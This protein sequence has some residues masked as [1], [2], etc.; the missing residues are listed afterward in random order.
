MREGGG[1]VGDCCVWHG[2]VINKNL[3]TSDLLASCHL[4]PLDETGHLHG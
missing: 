1:F 2:T 4:Y 3:Q